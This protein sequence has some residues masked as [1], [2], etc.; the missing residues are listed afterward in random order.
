MGRTPVVLSRHQD[1]AIHVLRNRCGH[2]GAAVVGQRCGTAKYFQCMYHGWMYETNGA[3]HA[4][5]QRKG[6]DDTCLDLASADYGMTPVPR[7]ASCRGFVFASL[8]PEG[9][10]LETFLGPT[11]HSLDNVSDRAPSGELEV[12]GGSFRVLLRCNWKMMLE[13]LND[14]MHPM[15]AHISSTE[16]AE[17]LEAS[18]PE[19]V[20]PPPEVPLLTSNGWPYDFWNGLR[21]LCCDHG[22]S[23][24]GAINTP[25]D[26]DPV[27]TG[28][29]R[30]LE[31]SYGAERTEQILSYPSVFTLI[32]P[33]L[34][35]HT[36]YQQ[37][38]VIHPVSV[39]RTIVDIWTLGLKGAPEE[40]YQRTR[41]YANLV[42]SPSSIGNCDD[43][44]AFM[45][46]H[47]GLDGDPREWVSQHR[48]FGRDQP[49]EDG[50]LACPGTS[51][52]PVRNQFRA[53]VDYMSEGSRNGG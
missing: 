7:V 15:V 8:S 48:S 21:V 34:S 46:I 29:V 45:R 2:K 27:F 36:A 5:P 9:P 33:S 12:K 10:D 37:L 26:T 24:M 6:Y 19:G 20:K 50:L 43:V 40:M 52:A 3:L 31:K 32:Y 38:R 11:R 13:N 53:W 44:E 49:T 41:V 22:H 17:Q 42:N 25:R 35:L 47:R 4:V 18:L 16:A 30:S 28:Y 1:G 39:D 51:E 23:L 14:L